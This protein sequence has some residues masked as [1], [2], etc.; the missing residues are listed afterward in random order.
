MLK[1][2][3][4]AIDAALAA[5]AVLAVVEPAASHLGGDVFIVFHSAQDDR[6]HSI[7]GSG[8]APQEATPQKFPNG[9]PLRG[10]LAVAVP[11]AVHGWCEASERWGELPL[12][13]VLAPAIHYARDGFPLGHR[14]SWQ[15]AENTDVLSH[16]P[17]SYAQFVAGDFSMGAIL[18][19]PNLAWTLE[20]IAE[21]GAAGFYTGDVAQELVRSVRDLGGLLSEEDLARHTSS[22]QEPLRTTYRGVDVL[23]QPPVSQG[24]TLLQELNIVETLPLADMG[25]LTADAIHVLIEAKKLAFADRNNYLSDPELNEVPLAWLL[26]KEYGRER[27]A[28]IDVQR[29]NAQPRAGVESNT[30]TDT[31]YLAAADGDGNAVSWIQSVFH[32][33]GSG[34]VGGRTGVVLNNRMFGFTLEPNQANSLAPGKK[35]AHTLNAY[36]LL[37]N[38]RPWVIGGAPGGDYQ[39][40][41]N[42]QVI[43]GIVDFELNIAEAIDMPWWGSNEGNVVQVESRIPESAI[44]GLRGRGH[45]VELLGGW[46]GMRTVQLIQMLDNGTILASSDVRNEGHPAVW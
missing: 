22:V 45:Q 27:A 2:G 33:F 1:A 39:V 18:R 44:A 8:G 35:P 40:Q 15:I 14:M 37:K 25:L 13:D 32:R 17:D 42:L 10:P 3:G 31:T 19:Q 12:S 41:T 36:I 43:T 46:Q 9:I 23:E 34:V 21:Q 30:G 29:A 24:H 6:A 28:L 20:A 5:A 11:G 4:N 26:S 16:Y 7:N 38:G